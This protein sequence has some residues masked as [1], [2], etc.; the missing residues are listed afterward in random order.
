MRS[1]THFNAIKVREGKCCRIQNIHD[2]LLSRLRMQTNSETE[3]TQNVISILNINAFNELA[4]ATEDN[5]E[6]SDSL[7]AIKKEKC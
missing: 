1:C 7:S 5:I 2:E 4:F 6:L 3:M